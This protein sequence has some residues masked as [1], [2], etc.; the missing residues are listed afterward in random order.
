VKDGDWKNSI[1]GYD[2]VIGYITNSFKLVALFS[3]IESLTDNKHQDFYDWLVAQESSTVYPIL[4]KKVLE[5]KYE[6]YKATF[7][8]IRRCVKFFTRLKPS[9]QKSLCESV[10]FKGK[11]LDG[12]KKLAQHL[13]E[14]R[15]KFVHEAQFVLQWGVPMHHYTPKGHF[16]VNLSV[17]ALLNAFE[18]GVVAY[19]GES[20]Q[21]KSTESRMG[22]E[23]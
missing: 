6:E 14:L 10:E 15:S 18:S 9:Q 8:A 1:D 4:D 16:V 23:K 11:P 17:P 3:L 12:I 19:F 5:R 13:Y 7:G 21:E 22:L 2:E 20:T